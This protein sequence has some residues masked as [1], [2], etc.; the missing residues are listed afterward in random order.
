M[1]NNAVSHFEIYANNVEEL[2]QFYKS[3]FGWTIE[4]VPR[5]DYSFIKTGQCDDKG[6]PAKPGCINGGM[7]KKPEG[8]SG[9]GSWL[10]YV[11]VESI[12]SAVAKAEQLGAKLMKGKTAVPG[13]GWFA[14]LIDP[15][16]NQFAVW[17]P[18]HQAA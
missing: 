5:L 16:G 4:S 13:M 1:N 10:N 14:M 3:M 15:Q 8:Y 2:A 18:D 6:T 7:L 11:N 9:P 17:Q 12:E